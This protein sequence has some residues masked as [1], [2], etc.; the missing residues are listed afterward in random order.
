M[1]GRDCDE[2]FAFFGTRDHYRRS[3]VVSLR[4]WRKY[5][6]EGTYT[7]YDGTHFME[8][9]YVHTLLVPKIRAMCK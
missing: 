8:E 5:F 1:L 4:A 9:E 7:L 2:V 6:G 3:G